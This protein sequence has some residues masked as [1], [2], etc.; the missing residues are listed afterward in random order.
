ME[1][2][3]LP[4]ATYSAKR[5]ATLLGINPQTVQNLIRLGKISPV[6]RVGR[7]YIILGSSLLT[8]LRANK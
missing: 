2:E 4:N 1:Q 3:I 7:K 6:Q 5:A 8:F